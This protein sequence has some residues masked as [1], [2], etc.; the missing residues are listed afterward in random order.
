MS[1]TK[2]PPAT[3]ET[4]RA[5]IAEALANLTAYAKRQPRVVHRF[6]ADP[7]TRWDVAHERIDAALT[8]WQA[9]GD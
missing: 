2:A 1:D 3:D 7:P 9:A 4:T 8:S 6:E 5:D